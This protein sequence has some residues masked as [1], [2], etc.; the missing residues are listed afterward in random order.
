MQTK[1][2]T[3]IF[4]N[5]GINNKEKEEAAADLGN[6]I[7]S[8]SSQKTQK[9]LVKQWKEYLEKQIIDCQEML[10]LLKNKP[11]FP[12]PEQKIDNTNPSL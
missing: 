7:F 5:L 10:F 11:N 1:F 2:Y 12:T 8:E 4:L 3:W 9:E 6:G